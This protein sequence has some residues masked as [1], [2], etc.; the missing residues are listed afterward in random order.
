MGATA[1]LMADDI[2]VAWLK[3]KLQGA[4]DRITRGDVNTEALL[5]KWNEVGRSIV[6]VGG[7]SS[8][9]KRELHVSDFTGS[10]KEFCH[11]R[12]VVRWLNGDNKERRGTWVHYD[13]KFR[14]AKWWLLFEVA[15]ILLEYQPV[16]KLG[17]LQGHPDF[18][19][20]WGKGPSIIELTGHDSKIDV[21]MRM[22]RLHVKRRQ[23]TIYQL[24][25]KKSR[26]IDK[27]KTSLHRG[28]VIAEDKGNNTFSIEPI[29]I[30]N[31][32]AAVLLERIITASTHCKAMGGA[33]T[34]EERIALYAAIP[35]CVRKT[36]KTCYPGGVAN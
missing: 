35:R 6:G 2:D 5:E 1:K 25:W 14:E 23:N 33:V 20:D 12:L 9:R 3:V 15:G 21:A 31:E 19:I 22:M 17:A 30:D 13:G 11:R 27:A 7:Q 28:F 34:K 29:D 26:Q 16:L 18:V 4:L 10:E 36:C 24:M 8:T 32:K